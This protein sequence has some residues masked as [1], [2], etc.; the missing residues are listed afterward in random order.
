M[1]N[2]MAYSAIVT[3]IKAM[4]RWRLTDQ[5]FEEMAELENVP[6]AV[7]YLKENPSYETLFSR[8][9]QYHL[10]PGMIEHQLHQELDRY[11][12]STQRFAQLPQPRLM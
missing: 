6:E 8:F 7:A 9:S 2:L 1:G 11:F 3:K 4:E 10:H 12:I 5:Q